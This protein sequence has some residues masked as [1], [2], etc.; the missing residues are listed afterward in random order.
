MLISTASGIAR[1][2]VYCSTNYVGSTLQLVGTETAIAAMT[3]IEI[4]IPAEDFNYPDA[5]DYSGDWSDLING[6]TTI[7][8]NSDNRAYTFDGAAVVL[9]SKTV[10]EAVGIAW[11]R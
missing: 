3:D 5:Y 8:I 6:G 2:I 9:V 11:V 1:E 10:D 4:Q 7:L